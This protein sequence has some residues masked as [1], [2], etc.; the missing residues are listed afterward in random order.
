MSVFSPFTP[1]ALAPGDVQRELAGCSLARQRELREYVR[2]M[3]AMYEEHAAMI[4][5]SLQDEE[6]SRSMKA[7]Y[8]ASAY[9][10]VGGHTVPAVNSWKVYELEEVEKK[11][12][13][14]NI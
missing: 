14:W 9:V 12:E 11:K 1:T 3:R 2:K 7:G 8:A 6:V 13:C 4:R 10:S 5:R